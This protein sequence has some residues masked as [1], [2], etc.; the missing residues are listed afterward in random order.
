MI[1]GGRHLATRAPRVLLDGRPLENGRRS[2]NWAVFD[3]DLSAGAHVLELPS[4]EGG[5][6]SEADYLYFAAVVRR[7]L[8]A[9][10]L[11]APQK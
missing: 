11:E 2:S 5:P 7:D 8:A 9:R 10:Y 4:H 3:T 6:D 1:L